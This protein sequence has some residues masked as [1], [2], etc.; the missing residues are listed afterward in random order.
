MLEGQSLPWNTI[1]N[2]SDQ[3]PSQ[4][5]SLPERAAE[6]VHM[7]KSQGWGNVWNQLSSKSAYESLDEEAEYERELS[8]SQDR[9]RQ[10][11]IT[12]FLRSDRRCILKIRFIN[13]IHK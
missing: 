7:R 1:K 5:M 8:A 3:E 12:P 2:E 6:Y 4:P 10:K 9:M 13:K 11:D